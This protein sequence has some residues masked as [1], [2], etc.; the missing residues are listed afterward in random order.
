MNSFVFALNAVLPIILLVT[1]GYILKLFGLINT[2]FSKMTNKMIFRI[3]LPAMLFL[4]VYKIQNL[5]GIDFRYII[6][7]SVVIV[8]VFLI[9]I[10]LVFFIS[11]ESKSRGPLLQGAFRSNF[12]LIGIPLAQMLYGSEGAAI[13]TLLSAVTIPLYNVLAVISLSLFVNN[14][15]FS[16]KR[17]IINIIKNPLIQSIAIG[18]VVLYIR[19]WFVKLG[20]DFRLENLKP[21][22]SV[23]NYLS[24]L[25][26]PLALLVLGA[27]FE[28]SAVS[29]LKREIIFGTFMRVIVVPF[30]AI[31]TAYLF[32]TSYF[33][34]A[35]FAS[36]VALFATP[37]AVS[38]VPMAQE[39]HSDT[40][41]AG[42]LVVWTTLASAFTV[43]L[44]T[45]VLNLM[46]IL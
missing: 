46:G 43:F 11:K 18:V 45:F 38:S 2:D 26:T 23:I 15:K 1:I 39:M 12:A 14:G 17:I 35:H 19:T 32:F 34:G 28:F 10:P 7:A 41:L 44:F 33:N 16:L 25:A 24:N 6:Y 31:G 8:L 36:F 20:I 27:Q 22:F 5:S 37:V 9:S 29:S 3:F 42:Q 30:L 4:N 13:A 40:V 21:I